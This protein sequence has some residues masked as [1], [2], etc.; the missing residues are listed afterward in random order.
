VILG[1]HG[2]EIEV[3]ESTTRIPLHFAVAV[4][5]RIDG[6]AIN[7]LP[8][9]LRDLFDVPDLQDTDDEIANGTFV[10]PPG[11]PYPLAH[12]TAPR[13]D[14]SLQRRTTPAPG[15]TIFRIS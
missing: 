3:G 4:T 14:Y 1:N 13:V 11:G 10:P 9:P 12:F 6:E 5:D 8:I 7:A 15:P 2:G